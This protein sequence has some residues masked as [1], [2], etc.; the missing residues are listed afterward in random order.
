MNQVAILKRDMRHAG[1]LEKQISRIIQ[2]F[3]E[4]Q[5]P[6]TL[7]TAIPTKAENLAFG[8]MRKL[9]RFD[10]REEGCINS[11][12]PSSR[13]SNLEVLAR[14]K[15][16]IFSFSGY[17]SPCA[18]ENIRV[19]SQPLKSHLTYRKINEFD[20]FCQNS[21]KKHPH[22][23]VLGF[24]RTR[25]QT[26]IRAGNGVH[27]AYLALRKSKEGFLKRLS[28]SVN[29]LHRLLLSIEKEA[30]ESPSLQGIIVN[31]HF[32][33]DQILNYYS[34]VSSKIHV[35][36]NGVEWHEMQ[37]SFDAWQECKKISSHYQ[38][39]FIGHN[40]ERKGLKELLVAL[41]RLSSR[42]F[43]LSVVGEDKNRALYENL[44]KHLGLASHVSFFGKVD[45]PISFYQKADCLV[46]PSLYDPFANVTVEALA[47]GLF[48]I[49]SHTNGGKEIITDESGLVVENDDNLVFA[50][51]KAIS[52]PKTLLSS[53]RIRNSVKHLDFDVQLSK[54]CDLCTSTT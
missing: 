8:P 42:E 16:Q 3:Q 29:P 24:E 40:F 48:V 53:Q 14:S 39:L 28:F 30:F 31:S 20:A 25:H 49:S 33:K 43:H 36:H 52:Y 15:N 34:T 1:G 21:L 50:L 46:I 10:D 47:M 44:A 23:V 12:L 17:N 38:F 35:L 54:F 41:S 45:N 19:I 18:Q 7:I 2:K 5:F 11:I 27:A 22:D 4:R 6:V 26:H 37:A 32:V 13:S 9:S 51:E